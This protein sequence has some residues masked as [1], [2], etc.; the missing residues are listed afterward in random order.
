MTDPITVPVQVAAYSS[1]AGTLAAA[2]TLSFFGI[3]YHM[4]L[5]GALGGLVSMFSVEPDRPVVTKWDVAKFAG[6]RVFLA[7]LFGG[8]GGGISLP[9]LANQFDFIKAVES[10]PLAPVLMAVIIG[11]LSSLIPEGMRFIKRK[12]N[13]GEKP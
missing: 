10:N 9:A 4:A 11:L 13:N 5:F 12:L 3:P 8:L 7:A 6:G 1:S 2:A